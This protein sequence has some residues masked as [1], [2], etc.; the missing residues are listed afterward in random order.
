MLRRYTYLKPTHLTPFFSFLFIF[1]V[2][3]FLHCNFLRLCSEVVM[4]RNR[5]SF[6][7]LSFQR[8]CGRSFDFTA[9]DFN[10]TTFLSLMPCIAG[11]FWKFHL[12]KRLEGTPDILSIRCLISTVLVQ[13]REINQIIY[14]Y[15]CNNSNWFNSGT[16]CWYNPGHWNWHC[17]LFICF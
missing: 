14:S 16:K 13:L 4:P 10:A 9:C 17:C 12:A 11:P 8:F 2:M 7:V 5:I 1:C 6:S 15:I 3:H